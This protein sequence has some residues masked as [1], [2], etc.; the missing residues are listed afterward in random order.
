MRT[1]RYRK[2]NGKHSRYDR[3][4][5]KGP[6]RVILI[7]LVLLLV[8]GVTAEVVTLL[9]I[10]NIDRRF[11]RSVER[12]LYD[13]WSLS[14]NETQLQSA[15]RITDTGF[16]DKEYEAISEYVHR[17]YT[18]DDLGHLANEYISALNDCRHVAQQHDP[19]K[20][21]DDFWTY[22][23]DPYARRVKALYGLYKGDYNFMLDN[24]QFRSQISG[25]IAQG[26]LLESVEGLKFSNVTVG[27]NL[28]FSSRLTNESGRDIEYL[29]L[30]IEL[31]DKKGNVAETSSV[32]VTDIRDGGMMNLRF[33]STS[34]K[35]VKYRVVSEACQFR[36][37]A[38]KDIETEN[39]G[40]GDGGGAAEGEDNN[41][42]EG[43]H[44]AVTE[45][46]PV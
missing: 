17:K 31:L 12:G 3:K 26:W 34:G 15:G 46:Q 42:T 8:A 25:L 19:E 2:G 10:T 18:D 1:D 20:D 40:T 41:N 16:I 24:E 39:T 28:V 30:D 7:V 6:R 5:P 43:D 21:F 9:S 35:A 29:N 32:Y 23:S 14:I 11:T 36:D 4:K 13:G 45:D 22:F 33:L 44:D 38:E 37:L 27:N